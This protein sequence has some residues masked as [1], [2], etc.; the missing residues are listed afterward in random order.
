MKHTNAIRSLNSARKK[1]E[2]KL[3]KIEPQYFELKEEI[4]KI[5]QAI[6]LLDPTVE[7]REEGPVKPI[8]RKGPLNDW[9]V[10]AMD[11][12]ATDKTG[13]GTKKSVLLNELHAKYGDRV[14]SSNLGVW[15]SR[16]VEDGVLK[17]VKH[18]SYILVENYCKT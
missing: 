10:Q 4:E 9:C 17:R 5:D 14:N 6:A 1:L 12:L 13:A 2:A 3:N 16:R 15:L 11:I 8:L 7:R 18:G